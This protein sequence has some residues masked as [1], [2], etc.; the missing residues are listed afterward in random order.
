MD[1]YVQVLVT[2]EARSLEGL[3]KEI[4][5]A[6]RDSNT[7]SDGKAKITTMRSTFYLSRTN[8]SLAL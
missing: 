5:T 7:G 3:S 4:E 2:K 8:L 6:Q 1:K